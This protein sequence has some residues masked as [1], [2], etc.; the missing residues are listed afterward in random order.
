MKNDPIPGV[1]IDLVADQ[2]TNWNVHIDGP[3]SSPYAGGKFTV[4][5]DFS[6]NYPFKCPKL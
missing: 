1:V 6:D 3:E 2:I 4:N 5:V